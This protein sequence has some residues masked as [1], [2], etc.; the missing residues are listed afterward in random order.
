MFGIGKRHVFGKLK[1]EVSEIVFVKLGKMKKK[2]R[3]MTGRI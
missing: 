2:E 3:L 1:L